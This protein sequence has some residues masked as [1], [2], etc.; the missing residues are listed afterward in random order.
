MKTYLPL[1]LLVLL[2]ACAKPEEDSKAPQ[3]EAS[4]PVLLHVVSQSSANGVTTFSGEVK[5]RIDSA[6]AFRV[7]GKVLSRR[8]DVGARVKAGEELARLDPTDNSL[9]L[10]NSN[11]QLAAAAAE[12]DFAKSELA[13]YSDLRDRHFISQAVYDQKANALATSQARYDAVKAQTAVSR[14]QTEYT[15]LRADAAG[16]IDQVQAEPGQ[17]VA[18]GQ[19]V[20]HLA[21]DGEKEVAISVPE[22]RIKDLAQAQNVDVTLW[23]DGSG[24]KVYKGR[25]R[26]IA[27]VADSASRTYPVRVSILNP[28]AGIL[29][30]MTANVAF[31]W[32]GSAAGVTI[33]LA[34]VFQK[35]GKPAVWVIAAD[36]HVSLR[37]ITVT[38]FS[39][40]GADVSAGLQVGERVVAAGVHKLSSGEKVTVLTPPNQTAPTP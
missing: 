34:S 33:P 8:V 22:G 1:M 40:K 2:A 21:R 35:D 24:A 5:A 7:P 11:A 20:L 12:R 9:N 31:R 23:A 18:A 29:L 27:P 36:G 39:E 10:A 32:G 30:G 15:V 14:N 28:D 25:V 38:A 3:A 26:E 19:P 37:P 4:R 17:V 13:R 16:V 6:L